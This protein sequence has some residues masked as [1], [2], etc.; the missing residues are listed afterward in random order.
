MLIGAKKHADEQVSGVTPVGSLAITATEAAETTIIMH[1]TF[2]TAKGHGKEL[3]V[4]M[5]VSAM[6]C[7][8]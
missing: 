1:K 8:G 2:P 6:Q 3:I 7:R 5:H 4:F